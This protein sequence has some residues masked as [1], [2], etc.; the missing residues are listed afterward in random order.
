MPLPTPYITS[1][2]PR[3][4]PW[5]EHSP[6]HPTPLLARTDTATNTEPDTA[7][8]TNTV[9]PFPRLRCKGTA[10]YHVMSCHVMVSLCAVPIAVAVVSNTQRAADAQA[11]LFEWNL[12]SKA[13]TLAQHDT[14][15][16]LH[17]WPG[18][19][20]GRAGGRCCRRLQWYLGTYL[21]ACMHA[22]MDIAAASV[23]DY[24]LRPSRLISV[25]GIRL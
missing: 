23:R 21:H 7:T 8:N 13:G 16:R 5:R 10:S 14:A 24:F 20:V 1:H 4:P 25:S 22:T 15:Q 2:A 6:R 17:A 18:R 9:C 19:S 3:S 11:K 12:R